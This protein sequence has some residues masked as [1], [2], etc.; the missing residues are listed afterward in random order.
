MSSLFIRWQLPGRWRWGWPALGLLL[1][2]AVANAAGQPAPAG[3]TPA[4]APLADHL[5]VPVNAGQVPFFA[6]L[7]AGDSV[8]ALKRGDESLAHSLNYYTR[9]QALA[10]TANDTLLLAEAIF[11]RGRVYDAWNKEPQTT[12]ALFRQA[13]ALFRRVPA[14]RLRYYYAW[15]LVAHAYDKVPDTLRTIAELQAMRRELAGQPPALL[16]QLPFTVEMALIAT[17]V[18]HY[19]LADSLLT[20]LARRAWVHN[21]PETYD[22]LTHYYLVRSRVDILGRHRP[23]SPYLDSL[24]GAYRRTHPA[25]DRLFYAQNL[26]RLTAAA[27]QYALAYHYLSD[28]QHLND[29]LRGSADVGRL[30]QAL[31][32][33]EEAAGRQQSAAEAASQLART[34]ILWGLSVGLVV[35]SLLSFHLAR[36]GGRANR[37]AHRL[38]TMNQELGAANQELATAS[39]A[40]AA[41]N[42]QLD[43]KVAQVELLNKEIQHRVKNNLH[44]LF[45]LL[46]MQERRTDNPE[47]L[48]QLQAARLRVESIATLHNQLLRNP[49]GLDVADYLRALISAVVACLANGRQ[50]VTHLRTDDLDLP[51]DSHFPLSLILNEWVTNSIKYADTDDQALEIN[52]SVTR[53][54]DVTCIDYADNGWPPDPHRPAPPQPAHELGGLGTQIITLLARQLNATLTTRP[55]QPFHYALCLP[56]V[57][58]PTQT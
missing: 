17:E 22:H 6:L 29:S 30:R 36:Q 21:D 2:L 20:T 18:G 15:H 11:A 51:T 56:H 23:G 10:T 31:L 1:L 14:Q 7:H 47:V 57:A 54:A 32:R 28:Y 40:V 24:G 49:A 16:R 9:A 27:G 58:L 55:A 12:V 13:T 43:G 39:Q 44:I 3:P 46:R 45:S 52:V 33:S 41:S 19:I 26:A 8:Y 34:R 42:Q 25:P 35:I 4:A 5:P 37:Q 38:A 48:E 53:R 50:V